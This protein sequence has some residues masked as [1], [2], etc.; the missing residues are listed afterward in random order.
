MYNCG[1]LISVTLIIEIASFNKFNNN[2]VQFIENIA[3]DIASTL[4]TTKISDRTSDLL[5]ESQKK[6]DELAMRDSEMSE[7]ID[8]LR[9][10]QKETRRSET[11]MSSLITAVDKVLFKLEL[12]KLKGKVQTVRLD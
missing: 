8:E 6:S 11:E 9:V 3:E 2:E 7:K 4:E 1:S 12:S 10:A 5:E